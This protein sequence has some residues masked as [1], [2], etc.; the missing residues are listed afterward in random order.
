MMM[1]MNSPWHTGDPTSESV[2]SL[3]FEPTLSTQAL[4]ASS[5]SDMKLPSRS[6]S[7]AAGDCGFYR[8]GEDSLAG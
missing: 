5:N 6:R 2:P 7:I 3:R 1:M 4:H 8:A